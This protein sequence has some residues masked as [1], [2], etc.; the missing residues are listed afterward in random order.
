M[1]VP[2]GFIMAT[3]KIS[4]ITNARKLAK[5][6]TSK[7]VLAS[8]AQ[9]AVANVAAAK[10]VSNGTALGAAMANMFYA[11][12]VVASKKTLA[13]NPNSFFGQLQKLA[14]KPITLAALVA[15][16]HAA[17]KFTSK[18]DSH[19]VARVRTRHALTRFNYLVVAK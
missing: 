12:R 14:S 4:S 5:S 2:I 1:A 7:A 3:K 6:I 10:K 19:M 17:T 8:K 18:K 11:Q 9:T 16:V 13:A 15:K